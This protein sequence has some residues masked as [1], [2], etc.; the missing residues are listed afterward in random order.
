[1]IPGTQIEHR[2]EPLKMR[3]STMALHKKQDKPATIRK[4]TFVT[5]FQG[6]P[7]WQ[8]RAS[9]SLAKMNIGEDERWRGG[10][11][12]NRAL[13]AYNEPFAPGL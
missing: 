7:E 2:Q 10:F 8:H 13:K 3:R 6:V 12:S 5:R 11:Q 1:M 9:C 4:Q